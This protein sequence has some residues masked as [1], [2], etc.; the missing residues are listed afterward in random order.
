METKDSGG[1]SRRGVLTGLGALGGVAA[2]S[3]P[4]TADA[5]TPRPNGASGQLRPDVLT[6]GFPRPIASAPVAGVSY[7]F[8]MFEEFFPED[9]SV[10]RH[11]GGQGTTGTSGLFATGFDMPVGAILYDVEWYFHNLGTTSVPGILRVWGAGQGRF[12]FGGV[13]VALRP[14]TRVAATRAL[15]PSASN[16]PFPFGTRVVA[17]VNGIN[18]NV[19]IDGVRVGLRQG[20]LS[21]VLLPTPVRVYDSR[22]HSPIASGHTRAISLASHLPVGANGAMYAL[23]VLN[24]H[25]HGMLHVGAAGTSLASVG[26]QWGHTGDR[27]T[28]SVTSAVN[29]SRSIGVRASSNKTDFFIDL[30]GYLI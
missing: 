9:S 15:V 29:A 25:G 8:R 7:H 22:H 12:A 27:L 10:P 13:D 14:N 1:L 16:G 6:A 5:S 19:Q 26:I 20:P 17:A 23:S 4:A 28:S 2:L 11:Y 3:L 30:T 24:T 21:P 18:T